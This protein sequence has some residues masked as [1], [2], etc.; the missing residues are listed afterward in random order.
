M[1]Y[2]CLGD[3]DF[4]QVNEWIAVMLSANLQLGSQGEGMKSEME[5]LL[6]VG[7]TYDEISNKEQTRKLS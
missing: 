1:N 7:C 2:R 5:T 6:I 3:L 4:S